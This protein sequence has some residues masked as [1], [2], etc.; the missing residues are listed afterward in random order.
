MATEAEINSLPLVEE[1]LNKFVGVFQPEYLDL[2]DNIHIAFGAQSEKYFES[3]ADIIRAEFTL[4]NPLGK[5][6]ESWKTKILSTECAVSIHIRRGDYT[7]YSAR[8]SLGSLPLSYY[9][10][11]LAELKKTNPNLTAFV[12]SDD[13]NFVKANWNFGVPTEF[14]E[15]CAHNYEDMHLMSLCNHHIVSNGTF[16]WWGAWLDNKPDKKVF[17]P[18]KWFWHWAWGGDTIIPQSWIKIPVD[19]SKAHRDNFSPALSIIYYIEDNTPNL[20]AS[21]NSL[22]YQLHGDYEIVILDGTTD[23]SGNFCR[24]LAVRENVKFLQLE[25]GTNKF[26]AY[27][28]GLECAAGDY[29]LFLTSKNII[30]PNA[31]NL[32]F[33]AWDDDYKNNFQSRTTYINNA[34]FHDIGADIAC[35]SQYFVQ[36]DAGQ[37]TLGLLPE[38]KFSLQVDEVFQKLPPV[39]NVKISLAQKL[40]SLAMQKINL[41]LSTKFFKRRFLLDNKIKFKNNI[42]GGG[43][44]EIIFL[45]EAFM[46]TKKIIFIQSAFVGTMK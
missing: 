6:A 16:A 20:I 44:T 40:I 29:V 17:A 4:K 41:S 34:N 10:T 28:L 5:V 43:D 8:W 31:I 35:S 42:Q 26:T 13:L 33:V 3:I 23:G 21:A 14:V 25:H 39:F 32:L 37:I 2:P 38:K 9:K 24:Q 22:L 27:N 1:D 45:T 36:D 11:A 18:E 46:Q 15:G 30:S 7:S 19:W 12:F